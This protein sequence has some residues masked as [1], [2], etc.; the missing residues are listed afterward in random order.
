[1]HP[2]PVAVPVLG[3]TRSGLPDLVAG[4]QDLTGANFDGADLRNVT[5]L[6]AQKALF[7]A[8]LQGA[9]VGAAD[10]SNLNLEVS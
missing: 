4:L 3:R 2:V 9:M 5:G 7:S 1:M 6:D 8:K 10:W